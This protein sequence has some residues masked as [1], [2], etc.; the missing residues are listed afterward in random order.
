[1]QSHVVDDGAIEVEDG[2]AGAGA[3]WQTSYYPPA[4]LV[5]ARPGGG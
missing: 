1:V 2:G 4:E 5:P 3:G